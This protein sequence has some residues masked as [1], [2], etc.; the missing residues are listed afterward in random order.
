MRN[1]EFYFKDLYFFFKFFKIN[2]QLIY[3]VPSISAVQQ[4]DPVVHTHSSFPRTI[5]L[6]YFKVALFIKTK[7]VVIVFEFSSKQAAYFLLYL[8]LIILNINIIFSFI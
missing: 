5:R 2:V 7:N 1:F 6:F 3:N 8:V 4:S